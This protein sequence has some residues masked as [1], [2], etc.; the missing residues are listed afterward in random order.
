MHVLLLASSCDTSS[1]SSSSIHTYQLCTVAM[2]S[3]IVTQSDKTSLIA[4]KLFS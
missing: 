1:S 4:V 2:A 3:I